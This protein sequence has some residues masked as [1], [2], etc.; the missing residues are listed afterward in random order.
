MDEG[1]SSRWMPKTM[2]MMLDDDWVCACA[3]EYVSDLDECEI[4]KRRDAF[5]RKHGSSNFRVMY[6]FRCCSSNSDEASAAIHAPS[7]T[8]TLWDRFA[9]LFAR[10]WSLLRQRQVSGCPAHIRVSFFLV[11]NFAFCSQRGDVVSSFFWGAAGSLAPTAPPDSIF[12]TTEADDCDASSQ[13]AEI[14]PKTKPGQSQRG[15]G[16]SKI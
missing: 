14:R 3:D 13:K 11:L 6:S 10:S 9:S 16:R 2:P 8:L 12:G 1:S 7:R 15:K 4:E 5:C